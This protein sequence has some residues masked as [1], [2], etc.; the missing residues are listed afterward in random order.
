M[1][2]EAGAPKLPC[3]LGAGECRASQVPRGAAEGAAH[4]CQERVELGGQDGAVRTLGDGM[5]LPGHICAAHLPL[6]DRW[7]SPC[8]LQGFSIPFLAASLCCLCHRQVLSRA[9]G[10]TRE[11]A[12]M[13]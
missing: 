9:H 6:L 4:S 1:A 3:V 13:A 2:S 10:D 12:V 11:M 7:P 5:G 8:L